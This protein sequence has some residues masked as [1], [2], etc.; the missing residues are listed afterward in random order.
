MLVFELVLEGFDCCAAE[1]V[2]VVVEVEKLLDEWGLIEGTIEE[3]M[4]SHYKDIFEV[5]NFH[6]KFLSILIAKVEFAQFV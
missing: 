6:N 3:I 2:V 5:A 4:E 1:V